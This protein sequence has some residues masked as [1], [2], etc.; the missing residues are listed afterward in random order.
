MPTYV[1]IDDAL[2]KSLGTPEKGDMAA[3]L[4]RL[5][6]VNSSEKV[7]ILQQNHSLPV[8]A[9][10]VTFLLPYVA[11]KDDLHHNQATA[12]DLVWISPDVTQNLLLGSHRWGQGR[13]LAASRPSASTE[14]QEERA[15]CSCLDPPGASPRRW[16]TQPRRWRW[17][18]RRGGITRFLPVSTG[19]R[20]R[21][22]SRRYLYPAQLMPKVMKRGCSGQPLGLTQACRSRATQMHPL[23]MKE[24]LSSVVVW[25]RT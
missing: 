2:A 3:L 24:A 15:T 8:V 19:S 9:P 5:P 1:G 16:R 13:S 6:S 21:N 23:P 11:I 7:Q 22:T 20:K 17:S 18:L 10:D 4:G 12:F 25:R 14:H